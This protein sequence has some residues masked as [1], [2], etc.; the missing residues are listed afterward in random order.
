MDFVVKSEKNLS[1]ILHQVEEGEV[2]PLE[3]LEAYKRFSALLEDF[4][5]KV[6]PYGYDEMDKYS[7]KEVSYGGAKFSVSSGGRYSYS[8]DEEWTSLNNAKKA[9]ESLMQQAYKTDGELVVD[10]EIIPE[11]SY[12]PNAKSITIKLK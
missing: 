9:R 12:S 10:G 6:I 7:E 2:N 5:K 4:K 3:A 11:A 8:H 1:R